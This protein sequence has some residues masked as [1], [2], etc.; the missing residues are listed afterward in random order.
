MGAALV[1]PPKE[2]RGRQ[3]QARREEREV[4]AVSK[5]K[6]AGRAV[7]AVTLCIV[8]GKAA[9]VKRRPARRGEGLVVS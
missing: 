8:S 9:K 5:S 1:S 7:K 6:V 3:S 4:E 2:V